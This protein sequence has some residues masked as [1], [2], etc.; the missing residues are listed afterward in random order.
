MI[1]LLQAAD[2]IAEHDVEQC[3]VDLQAAFRDGRMWFRES[4]KTSA[5]IV[6]KVVSNGC[7]GTIHARDGVW[8]P[9]N[10]FYHCQPP[11]YPSK[12]TPKGL[13]FSLNSTSQDN[14]KTVQKCSKFVTF[15]SEFNRV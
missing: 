2:L 6:F 13:L 5:E 11:V 7:H 8:H 10:R 15:G 14:D 9:K 4:L 1:T 12:A 3:A